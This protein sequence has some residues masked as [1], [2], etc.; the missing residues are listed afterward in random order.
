[1]IVLDALVRG[2]NGHVA[3]RERCPG[4]LQVLAP[5]FHEDGDMVDIFLGLTPMHLTYTYGLDTGNKQRIFNF[6]PG[7]SAAENPVQGCDGAPGLRE[8]DNEEG[9]YPDHQRQRQA[10]SVA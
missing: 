8:R 5:L 7:V 10:V 2:F 6:V 9:S 1:M 4:V 3:F